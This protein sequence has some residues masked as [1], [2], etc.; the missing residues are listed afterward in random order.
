MTP[1]LPKD[2]P[3]PVA[4]AAALEKARAAYHFSYEVYTGLAMSA[5]RP[6][7]D[8][9]PEGWS[10]VVDSAL[11]TVVA[12][13][14]RADRGVQGL[15]SRLPEI[16]EATKDL[17]HDGIRE[18]VNDVAGL[19]LGG[20]MQGEA[21]SASDYDRF[22]Q[23]VPVPWASRALWD[24][25]S[26]ALR[27]LS[28][29]N[30]ESLV[31]VRAL[32]PR[33]PV[34]DAHLASLG[35]RDTL[36]D[37]L[38]EG[39]LY[40]VDYSML[41]GLPPNLL[42]GR[43][44]TV[45]PA[46]AMLV[47][48]KDSAVPRLFAIQLAP[49]TGPE[50]PIFTPADGFGWR[51]ARTQLAAADTL[52]G[53]IWFHHART[54]LVAEPLIVAAHRSLAPNHP[55]MALLAQHARGTLYINEVGA[56]SVFAPHGLLDWFTGTSR[57]GV[58][59]LSRRSVYR[60]DFSA[61]IFPRRL[62][63]RGM[64]DPALHFPFRDDGL[65]VWGALERWVE[66]YLGLYYTSDA[67]VASDG[68]LLS[69]LLAAGSVDGGG[70]S[71]LGVPQTVRALAELVTQVIFA[72]SALHAA[73]NFPVKDELTVIPASPF[74]AWGPPPTRTSGWTEADWLAM[75]PPLDAAQRQF[76]TALL[77]GMSRV[78]SLGDYPKDAF[79]D[80]RVAPLLASFQGELAAIEAEITQRN[81]SRPQPY[82]HLLPS[83]VPPGINI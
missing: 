75:L 40:E 54:H 44:I 77:L 57:E 15:S 7:D 21:R 12:N 14:L 46:R 73:M 29:A 81:A 56:H 69:W 60:F 71:G 50:A 22:F 20:S 23:T 76:D 4:R 8:G 37:A 82:V 9:T 64:T 6:K 30:P 35:A 19:L 45:A 59:E 33:F 18:A 65:L 3:A 49:Q 61:S 39:R 13:D 74:G 41:E 83:R 34:T 52:T 70:I 16:W 36:A 79:S 11:K 26:F 17:F 31:L 58:R 80:P 78:G 63:E 43:P 38:R 1:L 72:G 2:D 62:K 5:A 25:A 28:G 47:R 24:E 67:A 53:A 48:P 51:I 27:W 42:H 10:D 32:D 68:E 55:L 66:G